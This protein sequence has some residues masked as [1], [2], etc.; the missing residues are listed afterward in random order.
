ML[1]SEEMLPREKALEY[2]IASLTNVE[3]LALI[4]KSAYKDRNVLELAKEV[5]SVAGSFE[6]LPMLTYEELTS[7]KGIKKAKAMEIMAILE[8]SKRLSHIDHVSE[9]S[10]GKPSQL[11]EW[12]RFQLG[13]SAQEEFFIVYLNARNNIIRHE[14]LFKGTKDRSLVG[15]DEVLRKAIL[16]KATSIL[17]AHNHPSDNVEPSPE[18]IQLTRRLQQACQLMGV[19]LLDHVIIGKTDYFSFKNHSMIK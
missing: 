4:I 11:V 2:G 7:I 5:I 16:L 1:A 6:N 17:V 18:D 19:P 3:L 12:L 8:V 14:V 15:V 9:P 10:I 13:Y